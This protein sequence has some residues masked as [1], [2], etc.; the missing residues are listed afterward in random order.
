[1]KKILKFFLYFIGFS[2]II[3]F[4]PLL[5]LV[6]IY[7]GY[8]YLNTE[9]PNTF[10][11]KKRI[12]NKV[13]QK[14]KNRNMAIEQNQSNIPKDLCVSVENRRIPYEE[15]AKD[16]GFKE[17]QKMEFLKNVPKN[18]LSEWANL[19]TKNTGRSSIGIDEIRRYFPEM[20]KKDASYLESSIQSTCRAYWE[21][22]DFKKAGVTHYIWKADTNDQHAHLNNLVCPINE[23]I[24]CE[25][26]NDPDILGSSY[27]GE[28]YRCLCWAMPI[29]DESDAPPEPI[30][31]YE[32][33][34]IKNISKSEFIKKC[35]NIE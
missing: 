27:P 11:I 29:L 31:L 13:S 15:Q 9:Y 22:V 5:I 6:F 26:V 35:L 32:N 18:T 7:F 23:Q 25:I 4:P 24:P 14:N 17:L 33:G 20:T 28:G 8:K 21:F 10:S 19:C 34:N 16:F 1:M 30:R 3:E 2:F 12:F